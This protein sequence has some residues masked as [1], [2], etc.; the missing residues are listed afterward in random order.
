MPA[1]ADCAPWVDAQDATPLTTAPVDCGLWFYTTQCPADKPCYTGSYTDPV[2][3]DDHT[4]TV[5]RCLSDLFGGAPEGT[6]T[7]WSDAVGRA[8][9]RPR[10]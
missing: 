5:G 1:D 8:P 7:D 2:T 10:P 6:L 4:C 9:R 3:G